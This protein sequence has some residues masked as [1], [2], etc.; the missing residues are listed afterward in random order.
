MDISQDNFVSLLTDTGE[1]NETLKLPQDDEQV[2][3]EL[4][5]AWNEKGESSCFFTVISACGTE[6][7]ISART[8]E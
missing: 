5:K 3:N 8:K 4:T 7:I 6:K 1:L 2:F